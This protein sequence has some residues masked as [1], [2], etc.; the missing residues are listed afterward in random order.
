MS[1]Y[2][3]SGKWK[4]GRMKMAHMLADTPEELFDMAD[5]L[6]LKREWF[7][8]RSVPHFDICQSKRVLAISYGAISISNHDMV[9]VIRRLRDRPNLQK[10][11]S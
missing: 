1:V 3:D 5:R 9:A 10:A 6:G 7:Q 8:S 4:L 11:V 2:V